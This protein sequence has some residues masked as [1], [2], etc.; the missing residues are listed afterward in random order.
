MSENQ[1]FKGSKWWKFDFHTHTPAS[2]DY[3]SKSTSPEDW[4]RKA[5]ET[6][7]DCVAVTDH[8]TGDWIDILKK[9]NNEIKSSVEKPYWYTK[10]LTI[11]PG[12]EITIGGSNQRTHVLAIFD[13]EFGS[14]KITSLLGACGITEGFGN[15]EYFTS[16]SLSDTLD[17][18]KRTNGIAIAAHVDRRNG[19][20]YEITTL[21]TVLKKNLNS[22]TALEFCECESNNY[23]P[24]LKSEIDKLA[25][26]S[27]SD[28]HNPDDIGKSFS[29]IK[30]SNPNIN[31]LKL[32]LLDTHM[33]VKNQPEN[34][35]E[36]P[37][38]FLTK[39]TIKS[40]KH[41]G[42]IQNKPFVIDL[43]PHFNSLIGGRGTGKSTIIEAIR[44]V[45]RRD[46]NIK[47]Q[48]SEVSNQLNQFMKLSENDGVML[49]KTEILLDFQR[50]NR[51]FIVKWNYGGQGLALSENNSHLNL[52]D[53]GDFEHFLPISI[54]SQK[55]INELS[56]NT[57]G[58]LK[59]IDNSKR[60]NRH[61]W[62]SNLESTRNKFFQLKIK[63]RELLR[64]INEETELK[65]KLRDIENDLKLYE[66]KGHG[67]IL[68]LY[69][70]RSQ[71]NS[72][73]QGI[74]IFDDFLANLNLL[75]ENTVLS[76]FPEYLF[77]ELDKTTVQ[78]KEIHSLTLEN[79]SR[80]KSSLINI[81]K[82]VE[83][84][85]SNRDSKIS[86]SSWN[87]SYSKSV[88]EYQRLI[89]EYSKSK[90]QISLTTYGHWVRQRNEIQ[91]KLNNIE[92]IRKELEIV[93]KGLQQTKT[94]LFELRK[95]LFQRRTNFINEAIGQN[96]FV[97]MELIPFGEV[98]KF[99]KEY[100]KKLKIYKNDTYTS[101]IY[102][103]DNNCS[104][105]WNLINWENPN[106]SESDLLKTI[107]DIKKTTFDIALG[108][109]NPSGIKGNFV[110][111]LT[112]LYE[113][114]IA[115]F[116]NLEILW[117]EDKLRV[118][119][120]KDSKF[121]DLKMASAGQKAAAILAFLLSHG[122]EPLIIDQPEDDL[123]NA[124][125]YDLIVKQ[126]RQNQNKRQFIIAT[127]NPN[128]VVNGNSGLVNILKFINGLVVLD[129]QAGLD[130]IEIRNEICNIMEGG[131]EAFE[132]RY[133]RI[134]LEVE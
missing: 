106:V 111:Y 128:I 93:E 124:L 83:K 78:I 108:T 65:Y 90:S 13:P 47:L 58:L 34:P 7:L 112:S 40:M 29:W 131:R 6:G 50:R 43:N 119:Y 74:N 134:A 69:Q 102:D 66:E 63:K 116:D 120:N 17:A 33:S 91:N 130:D 8:N 113:K 104:I 117:P 54:Y 129:Q 20:L 12:V 103:Y 80:I 46:E 76:D 21:K 44:I 48:N 126:I 30:M 49:E 51:K 27:S 114:D 68:K 97:R 107:E 39:L 121:K 81:A 31:N 36:F 11:F 3:L 125:I 71:Q 38:V 32:A 75:I 96:E 28:A 72:A 61:E 85:K 86:S 82:D 1:N 79:F 89:Y 92:L 37:D 59:I 26:V 15:S 105:L 115:T 94:K 132:N 23:S 16:K 98:E 18:I 67:D 24:E 95:E 133:K 127:H 64:I 5:I 87:K 55:Q 101:S 14:N 118:K 99:E 60:V 109:S 25:H 4:I 56:S 19:L 10:E 110:N 88:E 70:K 52:D 53:I 45:S 22:L 84:L 123:D 100:R 62:E 77:D 122:T 57:S 35:N 73:L 9:T 41:C 2:A 42:R